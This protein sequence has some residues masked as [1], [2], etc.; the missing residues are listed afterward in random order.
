MS[1][2]LYIS[3]IRGLKVEVSVPNGVRMIKYVR[4]H[5][6]KVLSVRRVDGASAPLS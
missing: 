2:Q 3:E 1:S 6:K 4:Q 5:E